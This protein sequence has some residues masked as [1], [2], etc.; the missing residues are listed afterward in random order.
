MNTYKKP[1]Q[2]FK[3]YPLLDFVHPDGFSLDNLLRSTTLRSELERHIKGVSVRGGRASVAHPFADTV[4]TDEHTSQSFEDQL[5]NFLNGLYL[6]CFE[7][8]VVQ[9]DARRPPQNYVYDVGFNTDK[10]TGF[11]VANPFDTMITFGPRGRQVPYSVVDPGVVRMPKLP[12]IRV[13][14]V[15]VP[16]PTGSL[17]PRGTFNNAL[18]TTVGAVNERPGAEDNPP[19]A[20]IT[21]DL[22]IRVI[23][24]QRQELQAL[25][26]Y[27]DSLKIHL[28]KGLVQ[29][30]VRTAS[31]WLATGS[32]LGFGVG[33]RVITLRRN[34]L[35]TWG[36]PID[37]GGA[38]VLITSSNLVGRLHRVDIGGT[39]ER[40]L[41]VFQDVEILK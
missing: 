24:G 36:G 33:T 25:S 15:G 11:I 10:S 38:T 39:P 3:G 9:P 41:I 29:P 16:N 35:P 26:F 18:V 32:R 28:S 6:A 4:A 2:V 1:S 12:A 20:S 5:K 17:R 34:R 13:G 7:S 8:H 22:N 31:G 14:P 37:L 23:Q 19:R 21:C 40:P 27:G 30:V